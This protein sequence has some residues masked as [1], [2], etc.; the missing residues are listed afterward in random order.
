[1]GGLAAAVEGVM[2]EPAATTTAA[3]DAPVVEVSAPDD[4]LAAAA[5]GVSS[6]APVTLHGGTEVTSDVVAE[7]ASGR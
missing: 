5:G 7:D 3:A 1:M 4:D 2:A 6:V